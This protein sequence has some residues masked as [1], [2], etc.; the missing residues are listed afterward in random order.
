M[1]NDTSAVPGLSK[2]EAI[3]LLFSIGNKEKQVKTRTPFQYVL[4]LIDRTYKAG[5]FE[6]ILKILNNLNI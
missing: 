5:G 4:E 1:K 2:R 6:Y 3:D